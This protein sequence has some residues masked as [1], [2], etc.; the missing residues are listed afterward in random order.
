MSVMTYSLEGDVAI[1]AFDDGKANAVSHTFIDAMNEGLDAALK[2][3]KAVVISGRA[4]RFSAGFDLSEFKKGPEATAT[5]LNR[6]TEMFYRLFAHPQPV[7][8]ACTGHAIAAGGFL[9][10]A[11]D[12]SIGTSGDYKIGLNETAIGMSFP[13]FGHELANSRIS[14]R[15]LTAVLLQATLYDP[16]GAIDAGFLD[17]AVA[18]EELQAHSVAI[19]AQ[20]AQLPADAYAQNKQDIRAQSLQRIKDSIK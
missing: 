10:L 18:A 5:L 4:E 7:I 6:G 14:K 1:L 8:A 11:C 20:L 2:E 16:A 15:H 9:L 13:V 17:E 3:A 19:A 12:T